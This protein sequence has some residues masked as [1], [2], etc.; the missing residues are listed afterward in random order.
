MNEFDLGEHLRSLRRERD[1]IK[2]RQ[3]RELEEYGARLAAQREFAQAEF[4]R[5]MA[6]Q[7]AEHELKLMRLRNVNRNAELEK[8][9]AEAQAALKDLEKKP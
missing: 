7:K 4:E 1:E 5:K 6:R 8:A 9:L 2:K 3:A